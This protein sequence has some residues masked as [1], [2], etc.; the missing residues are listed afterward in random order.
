[1]TV[2]TAVFMAIGLVGVWI[3]WFVLWKEYYLDKCRYEL[4]ALR[5][6][7]FTMAARGEIG[8]ESPAYHM[9]RVLINGM[10]RFNHRFTLTALFLI[11]R[12]QPP[13][14]FKNLYE[15]WL[16]HVRRFPVE[17][18]KK[19]G[20]IHER[21]NA[22]MMTYLL[23]GSLLL[24]LLFVLYVFKYAISFALGKLPR[25][26]RKTTPLAPKQ[27]MARNINLD[28]LEREVYYAQE[29]DCEAVPA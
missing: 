14:G 5:N 28:Q 12:R 8:F 2:G 19:L 22:Q 17:T 21:A 25:S 20:E 6:E 10:I 24:R 9:L 27:D 18:Q 7:L 3:M 4:F 29:H 1:M 13:P 11:S 15:R 26:V 16:I 23:R